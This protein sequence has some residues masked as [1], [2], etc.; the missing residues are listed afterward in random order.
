[1][2]SAANAVA[3]PLTPSGVDSHQPRLGFLGT[4]QPPPFTSVHNRPASLADSC[5]WFFPHD[6]TG[7]HRDEVRVSRPTGSGQSR[8]DVGCVGLVAASDQLTR[9]VEHVTKHDD[10]P[11]LNSDSSSSA[12]GDNR[13]SAAT[14]SVEISVK[15]IR[16]SMPSFQSPSSTPQALQ[17]V[18]AKTND[19]AYKPMFSNL[20]NQQHGYWYRSR[21]AA[22]DTF[23]RRSAPAS[24]SV[25]APDDAVPSVGGVRRPWQT[26]PGYGGTL[27]SPTTGKKRVLCAACRKTFC[28]K[29]ALKIHYSAVHLK[30]MHRCAPQGDAPVY[31]SR[32]CTGEHLKENAPA[33]T[34]RRCTGVHLKEMHRCAPQGECTGVHLKEMHRCAPQGECTGVHLKEMHRCAPQGDASV[35]DRRLHDDVQLQTQS[36]QTQRQPQRQAAR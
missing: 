28:D 33:C 11:A 5:G 19:K 4:L 7:T 6:E 21:Y 3:S 25:T 10:E 23:I 12:A 8:K 16:H 20:K 17:Y 36:Q 15:Q 30:E 14:T 31:T 24:S 1:M 22:A 35:Y 32:R 9:T 27:V 13:L 2:L 34:S 26:T 29:G 18:S